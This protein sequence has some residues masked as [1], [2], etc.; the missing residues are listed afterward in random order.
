L[1]V[2]L[3]NRSFASDDENFMRWLIENGADVNA[4]STVDEPVLAIATTNGSIEVV[5][6]LLSLGQ[7]SPMVICC[8]V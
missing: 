8:I 6:L 2:V 5:H 7:T 1:S 3:S 4:R